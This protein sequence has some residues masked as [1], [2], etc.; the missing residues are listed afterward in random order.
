MAAYDTPH[1]KK[2]TETAGLMKRRK[3]KKANSERFDSVDEDDAEE[4]AGATTVAESTPGNIY[5]MGWDAEHEEHAGIAGNRRS[6]TSNKKTMR[7]WGRKEKNKTSEVD[8]VSYT[9]GSSDLVQKQGIR[10]N[11]TIFFFVHGIAIALWLIAFLLNI[12]WC[13]FF[14][15]T[16]VIIN[17]G[18]SLIVVFEKN[19]RKYGNFRYILLL[20]FFGFIVVVL[21]WLLMRDPSFRRRGCRL[22]TLSVSP[23]AFGCSILYTVTLLLILFGAMY[24]FGAHSIHRRT[25]AVEISMIGLGCGLLFGTVALWRGGSHCC[26]PDVYTLVTE[27][28]DVRNPETGR[29]DLLTVGGL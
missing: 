23:C 24:Y 11:L 16:L 10:R 29:S 5:D 27:T 17:A 25:F 13:G 2:S 7:F 1:D 3:G 22:S 26:N 9:Y 4:E 8:S 18:L 6:T 15:L 12:S 19:S 28:V 21:G 20:F 14:G